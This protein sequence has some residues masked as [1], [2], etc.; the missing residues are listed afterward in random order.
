MDSALAT[1]VVAI[2][3]VEGTLGAAVITAKAQVSKEIKKL[4][5]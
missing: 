1:I 2:I 4:P 3:G 5:S